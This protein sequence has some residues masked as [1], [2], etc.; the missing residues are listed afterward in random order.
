MAV[1]L[2]LLPRNER[3]GPRAVSF[4]DLDRAGE[5]VPLSGGGRDGAVVVTNNIV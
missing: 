2:I 1:Q 5:V 3:C 4:G